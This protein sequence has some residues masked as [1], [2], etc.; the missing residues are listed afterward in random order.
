[1]VTF[2]FPLILSFVLFDALKIHLSCYLLLS[3]NIIC[4]LSV[5]LVFN[6]RIFSSR[7]HDF[8]SLLRS[9]EAYCSKNSV[10][11]FLTKLP[12]PY[13]K[14]YYIIGCVVVLFH[15]PGGKLSHVLKTLVI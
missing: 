4:S 9:L 12:H 5:T 2:Y 8:I 3:F 6:L 7:S 13:N 10:I 14:K 1:S 15:Y 11:F